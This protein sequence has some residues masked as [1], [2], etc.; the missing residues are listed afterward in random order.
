MG[1]EIGNEINRYG[2]WASL[3]A[4][5][6]SFATAIVATPGAMLIG[7]AGGGGDALSLSTPFAAS[8]SAKFGSKLVLLTQHYYAGTANT[9][10]ATTARLQ[11]PDPDPAT[12]E[13]GLVGTLSTMNTAATTYKIP[14]AYRCGECN[15]FSGHGQMGV[16]DTLIAGLWALDL[17]FVTAEHGGSG[18]NF[19]GGEL[20]MDGSKAFYY[21]PIMENSG[22][23]TQVQPEY[24]G[25]LMFALAGQGAMVSTAVNAAGN[26]DFTAYAIKADGLTSV[27]LD[28]KSATTDM[29]ITVDL[30]S[31]VTSASAIYL[32]GMTAGTL[33]AA[34]GTVTLGG[35]LVSTD[36][37]WTHN[38]PYIQ[39]TSGNT[40]SVY[41][42][43]ASAALVRV[44]Q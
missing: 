6:E 43:A 3:Q 29:T 42:P 15:T 20:G 28:N 21:M 33:T 37:V 23:V 34:A 24:Y 27:V 36:G 14:D 5:W 41:V 31:P 10:T 8:E 35:G 26:P 13:D 1:F 38:A 17:L 9:T 39:T 25:M 44:L 18:V 2:T 22:V 12:S 19:H 7:P 4:E 11:T 30:G 40:A 16:S 32:Q